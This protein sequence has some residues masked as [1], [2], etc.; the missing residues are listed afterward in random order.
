MS[1]W[2]DTYLSIGP[3]TAEIPGGLRAIRKLAASVGWDFGSCDLLRQ[4]YAQD[5]VSPHK[6]QTR[7]FSKNS[8][9]AGSSARPIARS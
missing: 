4:D 3:S 1:P 5:E 6:N 9:T 7:F 8:L 2:R